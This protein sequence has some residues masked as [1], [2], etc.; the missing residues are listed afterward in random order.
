MNTART[1]LSRLLQGLALVVAVVILNFVL[2]HAAPGD[3]V[4]TIAS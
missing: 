2:V 3:P 4:D 1:V